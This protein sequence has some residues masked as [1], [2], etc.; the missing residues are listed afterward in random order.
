[1]DQFFQFL[2]NHYVLSSTFF[3]LL[4]AF[5]IVESKRDRKSVV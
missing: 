5:F 3:G 2:A 4:I 1:M